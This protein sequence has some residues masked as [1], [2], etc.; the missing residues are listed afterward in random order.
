LNPTLSQ[1][2]VKARLAVPTVGQC[3]PSV[4]HKI[5]VLHR[6]MFEITSEH[7]QFAKIPVE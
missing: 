3:G 7:K 5:L 6:H 1:L 2:A 4:E